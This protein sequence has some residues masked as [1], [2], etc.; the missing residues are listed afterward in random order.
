M[1]KINHKKPVEDAASVPAK[2][3]TEDDAKTDLLTELD[4]AAES[5]VDVI[6]AYNERIQARNIHGHIHS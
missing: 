4:T 3:N 5:P 6:K 2:G 1:P